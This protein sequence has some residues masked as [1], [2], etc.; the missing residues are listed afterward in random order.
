MNILQE[1]KEIEAQI[2]NDRRELHKIPEVGFYLP[3]TSEYVKSRLNEMGIS[4]KDCGKISEEVTEKYAKAGFPRQDKT[5]GIVALIGQGEPCILLRADMDGLPMP[6]PDKFD[7]KSTH[8]NRMHACGHDAHTAMLL[9]AASI[10]KKHEKELKGTVKLMFQ[11]GE[12]WGCGSKLMIDDGL[13]ENPKVDAA[14]GIHIMPDE[15]KNTISY[16]NDVVSASFDSYMLNIK[17]KGGHS[18]M[19]QKA[20][21]PNMIA[22]QLYTQLNLLF[23]REVD[24][25]AT[26]S[27]VVGAINGGTAPNIIPETANLSFGT[28]TLNIDARNHVVER[29]P[30]FVDHMVKM[31]RGEYSMTSFHTPSTYNNPE[32]VKQFLPSLNEVFGEENVI[33][34]PPLPGSEDFGYVSE[35]VPGMFA[36]LGVGK[37]GNATVHNPEMEIEEE[38][39]KYGS[40]AHAQVAIDFL[41]NFN[42]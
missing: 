30:E 18:S 41:N 34:V 12:E 40:A 23:G 15:R 33:N 1:A 24:P 39:L 10:L 37:P 32:L 26:V 31:W 6:E 5:S 2:I 16:A 35:K 14:F 4:Y 22:T 38:S 13:L 21:D 20:I 36:V 9:G 19:P 17:G 29:I 7:F 27:F 28:R 42:K 8:E 3:K 25:A 11:T